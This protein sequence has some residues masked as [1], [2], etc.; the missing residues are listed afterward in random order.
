MSK[1][2]KGL[3]AGEW[4]VSAPSPLTSLVLLL[5]ERS[6]VCAEIALIWLVCRT[7]SSS[8]TSMDATRLWDSCS[9]FSRRN[10]VSQQRAVV[11]A[12]C[13]SLG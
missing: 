1:T 6:T 9:P 10:F 5:G 11:W 2:A 4:D 8:T 12:V 13:S 3:H 7:L